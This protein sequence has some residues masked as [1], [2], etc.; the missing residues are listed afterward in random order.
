MKEF[1]GALA[2]LL[3]LI[4]VFT[5]ALGTYA[6]PEVDETDPE[7]MYKLYI[8][9]YLKEDIKSTG[10]TQEELLNIKAAELGI[11]ERTLYRKIKELNLEEE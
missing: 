8:S 1:K 2:V 6:A 7:F 9:D 3:S 10:K 5:M 11:S 4:L